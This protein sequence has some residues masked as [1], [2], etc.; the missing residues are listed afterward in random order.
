MIIE[1][2]SSE[3]CNCTTFIEKGGKSS[4]MLEDDAVL[5]KEIEG[6][7][8]NDCMRQYHELM[9]WEPYISFDE[10]E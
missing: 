5:F 4:A 1:V 3:I 10:E 7:D 6:I 9:G 8:M 2:Y